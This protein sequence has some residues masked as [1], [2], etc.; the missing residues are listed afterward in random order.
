M[1]KNKKHFRWVAAVI[2]A[3]SVLASGTGAAA[4][5]PG[6]AGSSLG[7]YGDTGSA[8]K[9]FFFTAAPSPSVGDCP[10]VIDVSEFQSVI[11][12]DTAAKYI[13]YAI[14]RCGYGSDRPIQDDYLFKRNADACTRLGIPFGVYLYSY[15]ESDTQALSEAQHALRMI[16]GYDLS[17][18]VYLDLEDI[19]TVGRQSDSDILRHAQIFCDTIERAGYEAGIYSFYYWW[20]DRLAAA[21][22]S[23]WSRWMAAWGEF[24]ISYMTMTAGNSAARGVLRVFP[25]MLT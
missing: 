23:S 19:A 16:E 10:L 11:D 13:D 22:Y 8:K 15:A 4:S 20:I 18:P 14:I 9:T 12:W 2:I 21:E 1:R 7:G 5:G 24:D 3:L 17:L 25:V 6:T